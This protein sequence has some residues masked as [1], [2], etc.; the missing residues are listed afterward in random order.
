M[1]QIRGVVLPDR[2]ERTFWI[3]GEVLRS[4]HVRNAELIIDKGWIL[5]GLVDVHTHPGTESSEDKFD[6][7]KLRQHLIDQRDSGTLAIRTPG[8]AARLPSWV[9]DDPELPRVRAGGR[10]LATPGRFFSGYGRDVTEP[11]LVAACVEETLASGGWCKVIGD[12]DFDKPPV[13]LDILT[14]ATKAVHEIGGRVAVH[15]M[16]ADGCRNAVMAGVD[17]LEHGMHLE[18]ALLDRMAAQGTALVP[19]LAAFGDYVDQVRAA[20]ATPTRDWWLSGW[21]GM[22]PNA[23]A[24]HEA[25]VTV[26]AGTDTVPFGTVANE[27][28]W[29]VRAGLPAEAAVAAASWQARSWLGLGGLGEGAPADLVVYDA[30]PTKDPSILSAPVAIVLRGRVVKAPTMSRPTMS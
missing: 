8:M 26:L 24:A 11:E 19:T 25:G 27:V 6:D 9:H 22:M 13:P 30:D 4:G 3:D 18:A 7:A 12:W 23:R 20:N 15:C 10:W 2:E 14:A 1:V 21:G 5:P 29:L 28:A 17:S 16:T